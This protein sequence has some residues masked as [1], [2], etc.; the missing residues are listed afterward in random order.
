ME[1]SEK[2]WGEKNHSIWAEP[3][4]LTMIVTDGQDTG[5]HSKLGAQLRA[6]GQW[7]KHAKHFWGTTILPKH[8][9]QKAE[10]EKWSFLM[11]IYTS[12]NCT[13]Y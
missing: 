5:G 3:F 1:A 12:Q 11:Y 10:M 8:Q 9:K 2:V 6:K 13:Q 4:S 7:D